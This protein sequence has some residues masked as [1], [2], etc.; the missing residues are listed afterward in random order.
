MKAIFLI[1]AG[2]L[3]LA[4]T[5]AQAQDVSGFRIEA[6][7]GWE[8]AEVE[9]TIPNPNDDEDETGD[10]FITASESDSSAAYGFE[11][12]YDAQLGES[13]VVGAYAGVDLSDS[14]ICVE[15]VEDDLACAELGRTFT[16]GVRAGVP[17][18]PNSLIYAKGGYSNGKLDLSYDP[19]IT[20]NE[21]DEPDEISRFS[22][23]RDGYHLG[24]GA[25][26]G[27]TSSAYAKLEYVYTDFG[28]ESYLLDADEKVSL[29]AQS[30]RHQVLV[31]LG[32]RF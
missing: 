12:G 9:A 2:A 26:I 16:L 28:S 8:K 27:L 15:L 13:F 14:D 18:G 5:S 11:L 17:I 6:R 10:E 22:E 7:L 20:D 32:M 21:D 1:G 31:G 23:K 3:F 24:V 4:G 30:D 19:D 29:D 25:E